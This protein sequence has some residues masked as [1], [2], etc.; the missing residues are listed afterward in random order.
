M[1]TLTTTTSRASSSEIQLI[2]RMCP[3]VSTSEFVFV[4]TRMHAE[5]NSTS[6]F[7]DVAAI[8]R[9][10]S[11]GWEKFHL[12][13]TIFTFLF[14][15]FLP[16]INLC[17][18]YSH[19]TQKRSLHWHAHIATEAEREVETVMYISKDQRQREKEAPCQVLQPHICEL[20]FGNQAGGR[21]RGLT[22]RCTV[23]KWQVFNWSR[24]SVGRLQFSLYLVKNR[25]EFPP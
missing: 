23:G 19:R 17:K 21:C 11:P 8:D 15:F 20:S 10:P 3:S 14:L 9:N 18:P 12:T 25:N 7:I 24:G 6:T 13:C 1:H 5:C 22:Y 16:K 4:C 2:V